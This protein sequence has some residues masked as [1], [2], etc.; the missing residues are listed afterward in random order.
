MV[1]LLFFSFRGTAWATPPHG[2]NELVSVGV[3]AGLHLWKGNA[4]LSILCGTA[5]Y[6]ALHQSGVLT[7]LFG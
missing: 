2:L 4:L 7:G 1:N 5:C 3:V 6:M